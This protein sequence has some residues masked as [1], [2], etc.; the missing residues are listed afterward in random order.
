MSSAKRSVR[1]IFLILIEAT[2]VETSIWG[3]VVQE[4]FNLAD[5][6]FQTHRKAR[7]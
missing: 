7:L 5:L 2:Y 4:K 6:I 3:L 1:L